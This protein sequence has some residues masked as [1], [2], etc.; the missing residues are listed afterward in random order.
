MENPIGV[1]YFCS[2]WEGLISK[3]IKMKRGIT[4]AMSLIFLALLT[5]C[6]PLPA[7]RIRSDQKSPMMATTVSYTDTY[8]QARFAFFWPSY[9]PVN[10]YT[11]ESYEERS[12][13]RLQNNNFEKLL[14]EFD[15][16]EHFNEQLKMRA[17]D[18][19]IVKLNFTDISDLAPQ[20]IELA[21]CD[22]KDEC[23][24]AIKSVSEKTKHIA[25][26]KI[27]YGLG[28]RPGPEQVGFRKFYR[29]FIRVLGVIK[30][31]SSAETLWQSE[32]TVFGND[33]YLGDE[34]DAGRI[35]KDQLI[36]SF[37]NITRQTIE[38]L[39]LSL[40]GQR[41]PYMPTVGAV[42]PSEVKF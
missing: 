1:F 33:R 26:L 21:K 9:V 39:V 6:A 8:F 31:A 4:F 7:V 36:S 15:V 42:T 27:S 40:N 28:M 17:N 30:N 14:G 20:I 12:N 2:R 24:P 38:L 5:G 13:R 16:F 19:T 32:I 37:Q 11:P 22:H 23:I 41:L 34:A 35:R 25:A 3:E 18:S 10:W 29:P